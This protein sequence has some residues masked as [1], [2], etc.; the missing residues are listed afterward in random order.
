MSSSIRN[1]IAKQELE[2]RKSLTEHLEPGIYPGTIVWSDKKMGSHGVTGVQS[3]SFLVKVTGPRLNDYQVDELYRAAKS[4]HTKRKQAARAL[5]AEQKQAEAVSKK[6]E[7]RRLHRKTFVK[8]HV[9]AHM[10]ARF[11][12]Y[13]EAQKHAQEAVMEEDEDDDDD[14]EGERDDMDYVEDRAGEVAAQYTLPRRSKRV[15]YES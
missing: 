8:A 14:T 9:N 2:E 4:Y 3:S 6:Q 15:H 7:L 1:M 10:K 13:Q 11:R 5:K 12:A